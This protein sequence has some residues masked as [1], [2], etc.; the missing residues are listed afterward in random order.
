M[1]TLKAL[2]EYDK[3]KDVTILVGRKQAIPEGIDPDKLILM[4]D[5]LKKYRNQGCWAGGCP[6]AEPFPLW[7]ILD[8]KEW[9]DITPDTRDRMAKQHAVFREHMLKLKKEWDEMGSKWD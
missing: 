6:P 1:E 3:N 2:G 7:S 4:G 9:N 8:R 5:C